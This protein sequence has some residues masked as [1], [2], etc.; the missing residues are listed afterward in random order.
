MDRRVAVSGS[1]DCGEDFGRPRLTN[2][3][4]IHSHALYKNEGQSDVHIRVL[5]TLTERSWCQ[6]MPKYEGTIASKWTQSAAALA[7]IPG[8]DVYCLMAS[9]RRNFPSLRIYS[10]KARVL[11]PSVLSILL[12]HRL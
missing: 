1:P 11:L 7:N 3:L 4:E 5:P 2:F 9:V 10:I 6:N 12:H 8:P